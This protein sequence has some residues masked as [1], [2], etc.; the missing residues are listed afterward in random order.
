MVSPDVHYQPS[1]R[2]WRCRHARQCRDLYASQNKKSRPKTSSGNSYVSPPPP[3]LHP[4][5]ARLSGLG[6]PVRSLP[7]NAIAGG[8]PS[9]RVQSGWRPKSTLR[10]HATSTRPVKQAGGLFDGFRSRNRD[11]HQ[12]R[13]IPQNTDL[14]VDVPNTSYPPDRSLSKKCSKPSGQMSLNDYDGII[15]S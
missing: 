6:D 4:Y 8:I 9:C 5:R 10:H 15:S 1:T 3:L 11:T 14:C 7:Q 2:S 12:P 13:A